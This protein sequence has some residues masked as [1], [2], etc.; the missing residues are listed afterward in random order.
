[1]MLIALLV[2]VSNNVFMSHVVSVNVALPQK[3]SQQ[4]SRSSPRTPRIFVCSALNHLH[5]WSIGHKF[6]MVVIT[7]YVLARKKKNDQHDQ[8][9]DQMESFHGMK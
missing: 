6:Q 4:L 3:V 1:M 9:K 5:P 7:V 2:G 8:P